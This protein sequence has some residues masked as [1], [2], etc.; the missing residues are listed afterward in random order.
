MSACV[1]AL[2]RCSACVYLLQ[3]VR[4]RRCCT[5]KEEEEEKER[6][7]ENKKEGSRGIRECYDTLLLDET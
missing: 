2:Y 4:T 3:Y 5:E 6:E 1:A 7:H